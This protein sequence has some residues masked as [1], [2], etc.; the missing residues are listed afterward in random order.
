MIDFT[1]C[2]VNVAGYDI[3]ASQA[4]VSVSNSRVAISQHATQGSPSQAP[5]GRINGSIS[6]SYYITGSDADIRGLTGINVFDTTIGPFRCY[7]G[8]LS[9]YSMSIEPY[10]AV[11]CDLQIDFF[12]GYDQ[13]GSTSSI[14]GASGFVHGGISNVETDLLWNN[15]ITSADYSISQS[16]E[17]RYKLGEYIPHAY[18]R[19]D[20]TIN[21]SLQGTGLGKILT[22]PCEGYTSGSINLTGLCSSLNE[23]I[24][25]SGFVVNPNVSVSPDSEVAGSLEV[26]NTF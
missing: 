12:G 18:K 13:G 1:N 16:I 17:P 9:S 3:L 25:F 4:S 10:S 20:G 24:E 21:V 6:I 19:N 11:V 14:A 23:R 22:S 7:S 8:V 26:F 15:D 5:Q 2:P